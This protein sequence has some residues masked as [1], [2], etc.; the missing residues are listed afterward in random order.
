MLYSF[1]MLLHW[2]NQPFFMQAAKN[3]VL[4][5]FD[6]SSFFLISY[7]NWD[8]FQVYAL[9]NLVSFFFP[10]FYCYF[11]F[12]ERQRWRLDLTFY[13][14]HADIYLQDDELGNM[15]EFGAP[16]TYSFGNSSFKVGASNPIFCMCDE[17]VNRMIPE[18]LT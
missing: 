17:F 10:H 11:S 7:G 3:R 9:Y 6:L 18:I 2:P 4:L 8:M 13:F 16:K 5:P 15:A 1:L 12:L 14:L